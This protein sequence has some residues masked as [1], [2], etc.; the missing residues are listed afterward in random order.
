MYLICILL[1]KLVEW[2]EKIKLFLNCSKNVKYC[3][4][5][6]GY[7]TIT[8]VWTNNL[9][10]VTEEKDLDVLF[11]PFNVV[12]RVMKSLSILIRICGEFLTIRLSLG[13]PVILPNIL[14]K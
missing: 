6:E 11:D 8:T 5:Q 14:L 7:L 4:F 10:R 1:Y 13:I 12:N 9:V 3:Q 2:C